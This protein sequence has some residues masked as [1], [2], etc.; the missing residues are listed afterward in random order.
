MVRMWSGVIKWFTVIKVKPDSLNFCHVFLWRVLDAKYL[1][2]FKKKNQIFLKKIFFQCFFFMNRP[3]S[4]ESKAII[5]YKLLH[6]TGSA[7]LAPSD[8]ENMSCMNQTPVGS[9]WGLNRCL[10]PKLDTLDLWA[11]DGVVIHWNYTQVGLTDSTIRFGGI[12]NRMRSFWVGIVIWKTFKNKKKTH[13]D[14][15]KMSL[16]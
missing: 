10:C 15:P 2:R 9:C 4:Y 14:L 12:T 8:G 3:K 7:S 5:F 13:T 1:F 11:T 6:W 16:I